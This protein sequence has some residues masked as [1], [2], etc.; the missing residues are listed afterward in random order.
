[1]KFTLENES[2]NSLPFLDVKVTRLDNG[3]FSSEVYYKPTHADR[4]LDFNSN[5][6]VKELIEWKL[7]TEVVDISSFIQ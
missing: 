2:D 1:M 6:K 4:Y 3:N 7:Q 5:H